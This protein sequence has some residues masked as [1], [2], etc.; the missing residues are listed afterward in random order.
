MKAARAKD[1]IPNLKEVQ[2]LMGKAGQSS[3]SSSSA[4]K[5][6][7]PSKD[8]R[9]KGTYVS[10]ILLINLHIATSTNL[11]PVVNTFSSQEEAKGSINLD[12]LLDTA[13]LAGDSVARRIVDEYNIKPV[14]Q[15]TAKF[16]VCS[17]LDN[18]CYDISKAVIT[19]ANYFNG[20]L[21]NVN[22]F[23]IKAIIL[24]TSLLDLIIGRATIK[25]LGLVH[26][27]PSQFQNIGKWLITEDKTS[28]HAT[29]C[30]GCQPKEELQTSGSV[31]KGQPLISLLENPTVSLTSRTLASLFLESEQLSRAPLYD[32]G[33]IDHDKTDTFKPWSTSSSNTDIL[34]LI[35]FSGDEHLQS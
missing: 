32:D 12:A 26:Q 4:V 27:V 5:P 15:S 31:S 11:L 24:D 33:E 29:K 21:N 19:S 34:S 2:S 14:L 10:T 9:S 28:A 8:W 20:R 22:T 18:T 35:H 16:S 7:K 1:W 25:K 23:E 17:G 6:I 13:C 3:D 30:S